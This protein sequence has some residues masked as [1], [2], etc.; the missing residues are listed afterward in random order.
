MTWSPE[1]R[2]RGDWAFGMRHGYG[3]SIEINRATK[4]LEIKSAIW[5]RDKIKKHLKS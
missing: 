1:K 2:Y 4:K 5:D 3:Q